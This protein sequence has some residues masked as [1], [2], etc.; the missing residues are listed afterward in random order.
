MMAII[1]RLRGL[2]TRAVIELVQDELDEQGVQVRLVSGDLLDDVRHAQP[3]GLTAHPPPDSDGIFLSVGGAR[4]S[5]VVVCVGN[6]EFR[7]RG[8]AQGEVALYSQHGQV[9]LLKA[10]GSV[11]LPATEIRLGAADASAPV[12]LAPQ[13][14][15]ELNSIRNS[16]DTLTSAFNAHIHITTA[17]VG[18]SIPPVLGVLSPPASSA[19]S[20]SSIG[21]VASKKV[22]SV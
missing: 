3:Y 14:E 9:L 18:A 21:D 20:P 7:P 17:T 4:S 2:V 5:G 15:A 6:R 19:P 8:L 13:V 12:A 16:L 10:D 11:E 1:K 22:R